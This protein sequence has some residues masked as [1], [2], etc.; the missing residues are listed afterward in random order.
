MQQQYPQGYQQQPIQQPQYQQ[1]GQ[2]RTA[3]EI[4]IYKS[5]FFFW[6]SAPGAFERDVFKMQQ[7]G[8]KIQTVQYIG[9]N[10]WLRRYVVAIY[11]R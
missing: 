7:Q 5:S 8:W 4:K 10:F 9:I 11:E 3:Q 1:P 6:G 2:A